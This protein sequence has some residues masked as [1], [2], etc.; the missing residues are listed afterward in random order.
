MNDLKFKLLVLL[1]MISTIPIFGKSIDTSKLEEGDIIFHESKSEQATAIK[2][3]TKSKYTH[4]GIIFKYG[5]TFKVLEAIEPVKITDLPKFIG[6]GTNNHY[7]I[8]RISKTKTKLT[9]ETIQKMKEYGNSLLGKHYDL[10]FEWSDDRI[11]CTELVWKLYDKFTGIQLGNLKTLRDFDLSSKPV[12][13]LMKK[14]YGKNIPYVEP[15]IS[16][17]DMFQSNELVT[18][19]E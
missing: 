17:V 11:Y 1:L 7:V 16:P 5:K 9:P 2:L 18:V 4:V 19:M 3:A 8:K 14:R 12:Q 10:Y 13:T 15:V 6:R